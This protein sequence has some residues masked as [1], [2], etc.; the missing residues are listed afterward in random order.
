MIKYFESH[1]HYN[2]EKFNEDRYSLIE[3]LYKNGITNIVNAGY[4]LD[5]SKQAIELSKK[6]DFIYATARNISKRFRRL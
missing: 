6:Y 5:G 2:D 1:A 4:S 3:E